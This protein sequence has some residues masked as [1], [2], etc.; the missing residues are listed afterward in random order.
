MLENE[1]WKMIRKPVSISDREQA[2]WYNEAVELQEVPINLV[3]VWDELSLEVQEGWQFYF[4]FNFEYT[5]GLVGEVIHELTR[6][7]GDTSEGESH[8]EEMV[9]DGIKRNLMLLSVAQC[10]WGFAALRLVIKAKPEPH[11]RYQPRHELYALMSKTKEA[12]N[13]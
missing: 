6:V 12:S 1:L 10:E 8:F 2:E 13:A 7:W 5:Q 9:W 4:S 11:F 3:D